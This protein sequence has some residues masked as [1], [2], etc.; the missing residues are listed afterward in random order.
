MDA[1]EFEARIEAVNQGLEAMTTAAKKE[2]RDIS[3]RI[4]VLELERDQIIRNFYRTFEDR[5]P[6][7]E[8]PGGA[9]VGARI[10]PT[11]PT[12][13]GVDAKPFPPQNDSAEI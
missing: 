3:A 6:P 2:G 7:E 9:L 4:I 11:P 1:E 10:K 5:L 8:P 13:T 12:R